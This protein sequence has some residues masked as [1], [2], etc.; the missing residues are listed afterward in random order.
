MGGMQTTVGSWDVVATRTLRIIAAIKSVM[1]CRRVEDRLRP[2]LTA[3]PQQSSAHLPHNLDINSHRKPAEAMPASGRNQFVRSDFATP[4]MTAVQD[5]TGAVFFTFDSLAMRS[6]P[7][8]SLGL[9]GKLPEELREEVF[10]YLCPSP[11][12]KVG[13]QRRIVN[14]DEEYYT[15]IEASDRDDW[16]A[17]LKLSATNKS[18]K[19]LCELYKSKAQTANRL[20]L[21]MDMTAH[22]DH[23]AKLTLVPRYNPASFMRFLNTFTRL[24]LCTVITLY[25]QAPK[26]DD[27]DDFCDQPEDEEEETEY[28]RIIGGITLTIDLTT[29]S[30]KVTAADKY[31]ILSSVGITLFDNVSA[32]SEPSF[33]AAFRSIKYGLQHPLIAQSVAT[34]PY[35]NRISSKGMYD[36]GILLTTRAPALA[37]FA[38]HGVKNGVQVRAHSHTNSMGWLGWVEDQEDEEAKRVAAKAQEEDR[39]VADANAKTAML[40]KKVEDAVKAAKSKDDREDE[41]TDDEE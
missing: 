9:L 36:I 1:D 25:A 20:H 34:Q 38:H 22:F 14:T 2:Y 33:A 24:K 10:S 12:L 15:S 32:S 23:P 6:S 16:N 27:H 26:K 31:N 28:E 3:K 30:R 41:Y 18:V 5:S 13:R 37:A 40:A 19:K 17:F 8:S 21:V 7:A 29:A 4:Y 39:K 11:H 35:L